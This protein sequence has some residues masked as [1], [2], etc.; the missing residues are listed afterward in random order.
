MRSTNTV[1]PDR[2]ASAIPRTSQGPL[3]RPYLKLQASNFNPESNS[4][5]HCMILG[6]LP[7]RLL[8]VRV[9]L[10]LETFGNFPSLFVSRCV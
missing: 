4:Y 6:S 2:L 1:Y 3:Y 10:Y 9:S 8:D 5:A 7:L